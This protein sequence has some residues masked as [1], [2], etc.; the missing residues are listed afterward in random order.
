MNR[1]TRTCRAML[2]FAMLT[3]SS[4]P[5]IASEPQ[6]PLRV[7]FVGNSYLY[8]NNLPGTVQA[9]AAARGVAIET[10]M[11]AEPDYSLSDHLRSRRFAAVLEESWDWLVLQQGPSALPDSKRDLIDAARRIAAHLKDKP[12]R[13]ALLSVWPAR[14]NVAMSQRAEVS[15]REAAAAIDACVLPVASA[16]RIARARVD[17]PSLYQR[18]G[19]HPAPVGTLLSAMTVARGLLGVEPV[20]DDLAEQA[21]LIPLLNEAAQEAQSKETLR[22]VP[23]GRLPTLGSESGEMNMGGGHRRTLGPAH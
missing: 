13:I 12:T 9:L 20:L 22:C 2:C 10:N 11:R 18:D 6:R 23:S 15:Y 5:S 16:W 8:T 14:R 17:P 19:L 21:E 1:A 7:L 4:W 3:A